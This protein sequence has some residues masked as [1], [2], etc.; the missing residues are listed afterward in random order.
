MHCAFVF[1]VG[2]R[3]VCTIADGRAC[4]RERP[5]T[6]RYAG[7][8][9]VMVYCDRDG[10]R[11]GRRDV[12]FL[13]RRARRLVRGAAIAALVPLLAVAVDMEFDLRV[14]YFY[15][16]AHRLCDALQAV[17]CDA[18]AARHGSRRVVRVLFSIALDLG[19]VRIR[20]RFVRGGDCGRRMAVS[21]G[22]SRLGGV[23]LA[24]GMV[25]IA[26]VCQLSFVDRRVTRVVSLH[27]RKGKELST[28]SDPTRRNM[29]RR[30]ILQLRARVKNSCQARA[31]LL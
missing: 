25:G 5:H 10:R 3:G 24:V 12:R 30:R 2:L 4:P 13:R 19:G 31:I 9:V 28:N 29:P 14:G 8:S 22:K 18:W 6:I 7:I 21:T 16:D 17:A 27:A 15:H 11:A 20:D 23:S 26:D 1:F